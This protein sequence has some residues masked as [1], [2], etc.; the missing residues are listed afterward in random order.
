MK[1]LITHLIFVALEVTISSCT[2]LNRTNSSPSSQ[3][4]RKMSTSPPHSAECPQN[5]CTSN[6]SYYLLS[7]LTPSLTCLSLAP[8]SS[9]ALSPA[10]LPPALLFTCLTVFIDWRFNSLAWNVRFWVSRL[11]QHPLDQILD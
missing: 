2:F 9:V 6:F 4:Y 10:C 8:L 11:S 3:G 7:L 1:F 5:Y